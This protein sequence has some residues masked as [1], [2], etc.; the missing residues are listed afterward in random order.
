MNETEPLPASPRGFWA[1]IVTQFQG[2]FSDNT[3][4]WLTTFIIT[5]TVVPA[6]HRDRLITVVT[7]LFTLPFIF[8]SMAGGF[9][10]DHFSK[11]RVVIG[12]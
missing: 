8:F 1:L 4:R 2:A 5:D 10:A 11:R 6:E 7:V 12:V 3:L 9:L